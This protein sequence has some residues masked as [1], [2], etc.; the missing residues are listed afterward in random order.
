MLSNIAVTAQNTQGFADDFD[1]LRK[2][3]I[4]RRDSSSG[5]NLDEELSNM[6]IYQQSYNAAARIISTVNQMFDSLLQL[7]R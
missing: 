7:G 4:A 5:V 6:I 2:D 3:L 1:S